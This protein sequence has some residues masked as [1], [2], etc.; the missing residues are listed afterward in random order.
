MPLEGTLCAMLH[1]LHYFPLGGGLTTA[2]HL[3]DR[4]L[5]EKTYAIFDGGKSLAEGVKSLPALC[6]E[7]VSE[8]KKAW[9]ILREGFE[10]LKEIRERNLSCKGFS[11]RLQHNSKRITSSMAIG[12]ERDRKERQ[13]L[14]CLDHLPQGQ[15]GIL[16]RGQ[17]LILCNPMPV[18]SFQ[19]TVA[20]LDHR[21]QA[22]A[23]NMDAFSQLMDDLGSGWTVLYNGPKCGAS[24]PDH[25]HFHAAPSGQ[26]PIEKEIREL[27]R[28]TL[29]RKVDGVT[30]YR[31]RDV[32][33]EI[34]ILEGD[35]RMAMESALKNY[36]KALKKVLLIDEEPMINIAGFYKDS[37]WEEGKWRLV[38]FPRR[39]HRPDA[40]FKEGNDRIVVSP[41]VIE[42]A[43]VLVT[44]LEKDFER[45]DGA[46][47]E[48]IY[49]EISLEGETVERVIDAM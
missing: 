5:N 42:M 3:I 12:V 4:L 30:L 43:G 14:L 19:F 33:R 23:E 38:T 1:A 31:V 28:L 41:G 48:S 17:Y 21:E 46:T 26:M 44:P 47:V 24:A 9:P 22:I 13:C 36:L 40:F 10:N 6:F 25:H 29:I 32:G 45:L 49:E 15:K 16:Y 20:H 27:K 7:L 34:I 39:K 37:H 8:Q 35:D 18:L 2:N 11:V